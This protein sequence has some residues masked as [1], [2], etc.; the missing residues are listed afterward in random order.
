MA[1][2][3]PS[4]PLMAGAPGRTSGSWAA[5]VAAAG[6]ITLSF[7]CF[8]EVLETADVSRSS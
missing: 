5:D 1:S 4:T 6:F 7:M 3:S 8:L 2:A